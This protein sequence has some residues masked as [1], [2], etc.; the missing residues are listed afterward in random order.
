[1]T[2]TVRVGHSG[3]GAGFAPVSMAMEAGYF[4]QRGIEVVREEHP[5]TGVALAKM[6]AGGLDVAGT[7]GVAIL[8]AALDG[9]QPLVVMSIEASNVFAIIGRAG[10]RGPEDLRGSVV[11]A[12]GE[13]D[14]DYLIMCRALRDW[15]LEPGRDVTIEFLGSRGRNWEA[16]QRGD[17]AAMAST[18]PLPILARKQGLPVLRDFADEHGPYQLGSFVTT[19]PFAE[20]QP[21]TLRA[22]LAGLLDGY[23]LFQSDFAVALP[24][25]KARSKLDDE[26]VLHETWSVFVAAMEHYA[27]EPQAL[28]AVLADYRAVTG[29]PVDLD[30]GELV[31]RSFLP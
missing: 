11:A 13:G 20:A 17:V 6:V 18:I 22:F 29:E 21:D 8:R 23:R 25:M 14:Q 24:H 27:P 7:S 16:V 2:A 3:H 4:A 1:M 31:D 28:A 15:G 26:D 19:R 9:A 5:S 30:V 10:V 12:N